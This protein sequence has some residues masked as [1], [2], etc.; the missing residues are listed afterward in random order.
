MS[1]CETADC[2]CDTIKVDLMPYDQALENLLSFANTVENNESVALTAALNRTLAEDL[3][4][5]IKHDPVNL[6]Y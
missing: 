6:W 3:T 1:G 4:S 2:G 5:K